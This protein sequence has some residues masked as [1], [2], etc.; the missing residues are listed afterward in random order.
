MIVAALFVTA[1]QAAEP[2]RIG[3][4]TV[5]SGP[6]A[7]RG[8]QEHY[9]S[10]LALDRINQ[11]GGLLGRPVEAFYG[12]N[13]AKPPQGVAE[14]RRLVE[15]EKVSAVIGALA[16][17]VTKAIMPMMMEAKVPL[18]IATSA[19]QEFVDASGVGGNQYAFKTIPS[20]VDIAKGLIKYLAGQKVMSVAVVA[21]AGAYAHANLVAMA[22]AA[23][24]AGMKV[25]DA[26]DLAEKDNDFPALMGKLKAGAPERVI[27]ILG[28]ST[29]AFFK[30]YEA[31]GWSVP[32]TG[33]VNIPGAMAA[34]S[35]DFVKA[36]GLAK[37]TGVAVFVADDPAVAKFSQAYHAHTGLVPTQRSFYVYE[38]TLLVADAIKRAHSDKPDAVWKA[39]KANKFPSMLGGTYAFDDHN[40]SH[41]PLLIV[42][43]KDTKQVVIA[44]E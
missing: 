28:G 4:T 38:A 6:N 39:L 13:A 2:V 14:T 23:K 20:Q 1:A 43:V 9:G 19:G 12:D 24:A 34:V 31:S 18:I 27:T 36:G 17:P 5:L 3:I 35:P 33:R 21:D 29:G 37:L 16:T 41:T 44:K 26:V 30:A 11:S 22:E 10:Q 42:G 32:I 8:Q 15:M 40:H 25:T 7:D